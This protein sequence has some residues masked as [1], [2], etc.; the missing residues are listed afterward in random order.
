MNDRNLLHLIAD[1]GIQFCS[2][3]VEFNASEPLTLGSGRML[4]YSFVENVD[5]FDGSISF[6][7]LFNNTD[8]NCWIPVKQLRNEGCIALHPNGSEEL[9]E[10]GIPRMRDDASTELLES[11]ADDDDSIININTFESY[12]VKSPL[13][14]VDKVPAF[15][16]LLDKWLPMPMFETDPSG[17][18]VGV[19]MGWCRVKI[20]RTGEGSRKG[21]SK[22]TLTWAFDTHLA[23]NPL[24]IYFPYFFDE[25]ERKKSFALCNKPD[26]LFNFLS[27]AEEQN[28]I[29]QYVASLL[30]IEPE[31][32]THH[33]YKFIAY[34]I[35]LVNFIRMSGASPQVVLY[36]PADGDV[37]VDM[38]LDIG[39]SR[40]CGVLFEEG[41]FTRS[42]M[43]ELRNLSAPWITYKNPFDMRLVFRR[44]DFGND[45]IL[46]EEAFN[47]KSIVRVGEEARNLVYHSIEDNGEAERANNYS[48]PKRY[49]WDKK[50]SQARWEYLVTENDPFNV[51]QSPNIFLENFTDMFDERGT[52]KEKADT[53][54]VF[55]MPSDETDSDCHYSRSSMMTFVMVEVL[56]QAIAQINSPSFRDKHGRI[57]CRRRLRNVIITCPT[58]MPRAEQ[59]TL[60]Q[61]M[62]DAQKAML[63]CN[64]SLTPVNV[65]PSPDALRVTDDYDMT[66]RRVW[67]YDEASA[68]QLVY[69]YAEIA[70][71]YNGKID[72]FFE[73]KG[74]RREEFAEEGYDRNSL[75]IGSIDI[76]AG[77]TDIMICSYKYEGEEQST[78]I[79]VPHFY[80]SFYVAGDDILRMIVQRYVIEGPETGIPFMGSI[81][82]AL[83]ARLSAM[84]DDELRALPCTR[85][86]YT[87]VYRTYVEDI[88]GCRSAERRD[89][90][91]RYFASV[92]LRDFFGYDSA[93]MSFRDRQARVDFNTQISTPIARAMMDLLRRKYPSRVYTYD[94]LFADLKPSE[95]LL[96]HFAEHFGFSFEE[97]SWRYDPEE[98]AAMVRATMEP[99]MK[100]LSILLYAYKCDI[101]VMAGRP[102]TIDAI[103]ELFIKY[104]PMS[105]DRII[106]LNDYRVG[107]WY[108]F[109]DGQGYFF[110]QKSVVAVGAMV[111][112]M[113]STV[114]F[115]GL[116]L[117]F[118]E[119]IRRMKP[120]AN[121]IGFYDDKTQQVKTSLLL[122][123]K[124]NASTTVGSFPVFL[125]CKQFNS[126]LYQARP[127]YGLYFTGKKNEPV[128]ITLTRSF[129][130]D[131]EVVEIEEISDIQGNTLPKSTVEI[132]QQSIVADGKHWLDKG[133]FELSLK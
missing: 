132:V 77:T 113:A 74:H 63:R 121:Y 61:S 96:N 23:D 8:K 31:K 39:N 125:G 17:A 20:R 127:L 10:T 59:I 133:E 108:P 112:Y 119:M 34:Y 15:E 117:D 128:R 123:D 58:A 2:N 37:N 43:L 129:R 14:P 30:G 70:R 11:Y 120:T 71:R 27:I 84:T 35:Y 53:V 62:V 18:T 122:P 116:R 65:I 46:P 73:A 130:E 19:P 9:D 38:V 16:L 95:H 110:D 13:N 75:T 91:T 98:I 126:P 85:S 1:T 4:R 101:L 124:S 28:A 131:R 57:D 105:P 26:Q 68:C 106:C 60:R 90:R 69:L 7:V 102:T 99:L 5:P 52:F 44:A 88:I 81:H 72:K 51:R 47:W 24:S 40:T 22:Y 100:Q 33:R 107:T 42:V 32:I 76:G 48:S 56:Q 54:N 89:E 41:D 49:L 29:S 45:L 118:S 55:D 3:E 115:N 21:M 6:D 25:S 103:P 79:P 80:D 67:S 12:R 78:I 93:M 64:P 66:D 109:A 36:N 86:K 50:K 92:L 111:G 97:L 94:E 83:L 104:Y 114:G 87:D 82:S